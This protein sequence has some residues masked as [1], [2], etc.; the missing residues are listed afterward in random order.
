MS[1]AVF[2][3]RL[4]VPGDIGPLWDNDCTFSCALDVVWQAGG[5]TL[6]GDVWVADAKPDLGPRCH[7]ASLLPMIEDRGILAMQS[8]LISSS[9]Q[10][11]F[12]TPLQS[13]ERVCVRL[14]E[15]AT[16]GERKRERKIK[17]REWQK[18]VYK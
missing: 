10:N 14:C 16:T 18:K 13:S 17:Q 3:H 5:P 15:N 8:V 7:M 12:P 2:L 6:S 1:I 11:A 4:E 9:T